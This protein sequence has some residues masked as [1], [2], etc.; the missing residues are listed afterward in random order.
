LVAL[1]MAGH[2]RPGRPINEPSGS[3]FGSPTV[4][5]DGSVYF[6]ECGGLRCAVHGLD[7]TGREPAGWPFDVPGDFACPNGGVCGA[8]L[9]ITPGGTTYLSH[10]R[11][12]GGLQVI[13]I[14]ASGQ[15]MPGWPVV[16]DAQG[17]WWS[18]AQVGSD[19]T[20]FILGRPDGGATP[21]RLAAY[22][23]NGRLRPGWPVALPDNSDY[24]LGP[25]GTAVVWSLIDNRGELCSEPRR[26]VFTVLGPDGRTLP[27]WPR[28]SQG[29]ASSPVADL[30][31]TLYY[32]SALGNVYAHDRTSEIK[33]GWPVPVPGAIGVCG[34]LPPYLA[35]DGTI[36]ILANDEVMGSEVTALSRDGLSRPGW[37]YHS[38]G[39]LIGPPFD[40]EGG[41]SISP[42]VFGPDGTVYLVIFQ[43]DA[44]AVRADIVALDQR[45]QVKVGWPYRLPIDPTA[46]EV[47][48]LTISPD[49]RLLVRG[50]GMLMAF[51][52][53]G[54]LSE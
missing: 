19:G 28:G 5:P 17:G 15:I 1:D 24:V 50:G 3:D 48:S 10:W 16:P 45:A 47:A 30:D 42:P 52:P 27:G 37:P 46:G 54:R 38:A 23:P 7:V 35:P 12:V 40:S 36:Y 22:S 34:R 43:T 41:G 53:D 33:A 44:T 21:A 49:G 51:D 25:D 32:V 26:T 6:E 39:E 8:I 4:G 31:G 29:H 20:L 2:V 18:N 13:S 14:D 9:G 11:D